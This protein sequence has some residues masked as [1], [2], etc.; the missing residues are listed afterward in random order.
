MVCLCAVMV[1]VLCA[2]CGCTVTLPDVGPIVNVI[3][4]QP[5]APAP[6]PVPAPA[7]TPTPV[8]VPVPV[9]NTNADL[10]QPLCDPPNP[11]YSPAAVSANDHYEECAIQEQKSLF[12]RYQVRR[13]SDGGWY[14]LASA[15]LNFVRLDGADL[16]AANHTDQGVQW[17]V[18]GFS[19][20]DLRTGQIPTYFATGNRCNYAARTGT[21][22]IDVECR[23]LP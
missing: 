4:N 23:K 12:V 15:G 6:T 8:P 16:V 19:Y 10:T 2:C 21:I 13:A 17:I 3:T 20:G 14:L 9:V 18:T 5:P 7:P 11:P 22:Y 1:G